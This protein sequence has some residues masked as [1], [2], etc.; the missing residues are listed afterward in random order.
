MSVRLSFII[1]FILLSITVF[2]LS[3]F[4]F[5]VYMQNV[6]LVCSEQY[7]SFLSSEMSCKRSIQTI[8]ARHDT[9][10]YRLIHID[11]TPDRHDTYRQQHN[12]HIF[13]FGF[14]NCSLVEHLQ[15]HKWIHHSATVNW[16]L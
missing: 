12:K 6:K 3:F 10:K 2:Y 16:L 11:T 8:T 9:T 7:S 4:Y 5:V 15:S 13:D 1:Y 14:S